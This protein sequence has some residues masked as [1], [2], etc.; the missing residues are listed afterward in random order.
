LFYS[1]ELFLEFVTL[2]V[3]T[4]MMPD[5]PRPFKIRGGWFVLILITITPMSFA[6]TVIYATLSDSE[7]DLRHPVI[8]VI[9]LL[10]GAALYFLRRKQIE[11]LSELCL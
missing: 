2:P 7:T 6:Q 1:A 10:S 8:V 11:K 4:K 5:L 3:M 9:G